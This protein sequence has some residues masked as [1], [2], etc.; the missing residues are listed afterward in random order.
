M[1]FNKKRTQ[2]SQ[3][4][5]TFIDLLND[6]LPRYANL[7]QRN[8]LSSEE[9]AELGELEYFLIELNGKI[10]EIKRMLSHDL[11]GLTI[12]LYYQTKQKANLGDEKAQ[13]KLAVMRESFSEVLKNDSFILWN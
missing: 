7:L 5:E 6:F 2:M 12:D 8:D 10:T 11:F 9:L 4:M 1:D 3:E 13:K